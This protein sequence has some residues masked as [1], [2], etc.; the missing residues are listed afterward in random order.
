[1]QIEGEEA[2]KFLNKMKKDKKIT[3]GDLEM[4]GI[5][6]KL[7]KVT[8]CYF[9]KKCPY[10]DKCDSYPYKCSSCI[11]N[12]NKKEDHYEPDEFGPSVRW[13]P[14]MPWQKRL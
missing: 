12:P 11:H 10:E 6:E 3:K 2:I 1:M 4:L 8:P 9:T 7:P 5:I 14:P 13:G